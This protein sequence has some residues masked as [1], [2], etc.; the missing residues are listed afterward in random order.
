MSLKHLMIAGFLFCP[1]SLLAQSITLETGTAGEGLRG[2]IAAASLTYALREEASPAPQDIVAAARADYRRILTALY[3]A[4]YY[5]PSISIRINGLEAEGIAPLDAPT[6]ISDVIIAVDRGG[7]FD[8]GTATIAPIATGTLLP[9]EFAT[10]N[11]ARTN[12]IRDAVAAGVNGWRELGHAKAA[13]ADQTV[14]AR[15]PDFALDVSIALSPGPRLTFGALDITGNAAVRRSAIAR[16][17]GLP[18]GDVFAPDEV[19]AAERRLRQTGAFDSVAISESDTIG[20]DDTLPFTLAVVESK[21]RRFGF[22]LELSSIEGLGVS[23]FWMHRNAFGG[24]ER[25]RVDGDISGIGGETGGID[26]SISTSLAIPAVYGPR[27]DFLGTA[28]FSHLDEPEFLIDQVKIE[29]SVT[30]LLR[31]DLTANVGLGLLAAR[32]ET[33]L[34]T[35]DYVLLTLPVGLELER[36]DDPTNAADGYY[37][38]L[39]ATPFIS[40]QGAGNGARAFA[41][42]RGYRSFGAG[43][44][45]T[46]AART[47][48]GSLL[49]VDTLTAPAD[50]LF[51]SGGGGTVRGQPYQ[52]LG[53][54]TIVDD[55]TIVT[56]GLSFA[57]AQLEARYGVT[58]AIGLVGF[59]DYGF[60][61]ETSTPLTEGAWHAGTGLGVRYNTGIGPIR[62]DIGTPA[63]GDDAFGSVD[64]YIG[65]GQSF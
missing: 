33:D 15:H 1:A 23:T 48:I 41:D 11:V 10:G 51:Y 42:L 27:T 22:G 25:F 50:F 12:V 45:I 19:T 36:R 13:P 59:Y 47:Q 9:D 28:T 17:A 57:G 21:P 65:I 58:D 60:I 37:I 3:N 29:G 8:F 4:G 54:E 20:P 61:G 14:V 56:G 6:Q 5:G 26:Y 39:D 46:L 64:V 30:R 49:G 35:R 38:A 52:N 31:D 55:E 43:D 40:L 62:L 34:G 53:V 24:A 44:Q 2:D 7:R 18:T 32:E 63:N 16:I